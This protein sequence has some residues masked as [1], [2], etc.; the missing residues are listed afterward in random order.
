MFLQEESHNTRT[1]RPMSRGRVV[2]WLNMGS[3]PCE[4]EISP[5]WF[6]FPMWDGM[7]YLFVEGGCMLLAMGDIGHATTAKLSESEA[8]LGGITGWPSS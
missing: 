7:E 6:P 1:D 8:F 3:D 2:A 5:I 4:D